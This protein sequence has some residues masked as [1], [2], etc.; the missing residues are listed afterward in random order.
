[1]ACVILSNKN[2]KQNCTLLARVV[3]VRVICFIMHNQLSVDKVEAV[4]LRFERIIDHFL[5]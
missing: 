1:M 2:M 5:N 3:V 4:R